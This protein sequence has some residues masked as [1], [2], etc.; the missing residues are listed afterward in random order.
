MIFVMLPCN[1]YT[2]LFPTYSTSYYR[3]ALPRQI[4]LK[5]V[6]LHN[7]IYLF[8]WFEVPHQCNHPHFMLRRSGNQEVK[9][10]TL[11]AGRYRSALDVIE[12]MLQCVQR[13]IL[14]IAVDDEWDI[15]FTTQEACGSSSWLDNPRKQSP[16]KHHVCIED[17]FYPW[18]DS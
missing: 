12:G 11:P 17:L 7:L 2:N 18:T 15:T 6:G 13:Q 5:D 8:S 3:V 10:I 4:R 1:A 9:R 14:H 16:R